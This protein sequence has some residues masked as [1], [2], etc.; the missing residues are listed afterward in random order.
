MRCLKLPFTFDPT[1][2]RADLARVADDEWIP[3]INRRHYDGRWSGA[4]LRSLRGS[5][6]DLVPESMDGA[7]FQ[8][9]ALLGRCPYF[10]EVLATLRCPQLSVRLLRLHA[11]SSIAEHIDR[12]LDF[13]EGEIRVHIPIETSDDVKFFLDGARLVMAPGECWYTNVNLPH[14]VENHGTTDRIHLVID[15]HVDPWLRTLFATTPR[16]AGEN[17][18]ARLTLPAATGAADLIAL[19]SAFAAAHTATGDR[20][21]FRAT[22][23]ALV[24]HWPGDHAWQFRLAIS[25]PAAAAPLV[26]HIESSPD[27]AGVHRPRHDALLARLRA[28]YPE[29]SVTAPAPA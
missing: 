29:S 6:T 14:S 15:C 27:P 26:L 16:P 22:G 2:L 21:E 11:G 10:R 12:A 13:D 18:T 7:A 19:L 28:A 5:A 20:V 1:R 24:L 25:A 3:H 9:T 23:T 4:A 17:Y 8:D